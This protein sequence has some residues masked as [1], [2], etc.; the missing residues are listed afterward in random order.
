MMPYTYYPGC[1]L[2]ATGV[3]YDKSMRAVFGKLGLG[4]EE[5]DDWNCCGATSYMSVKETVAFAITARN[6]ALA[7]KN[8]GGD[9]VAPCSACY[10]LL[11]KT[12]KFLGEAPA[13]RADVAEAL[14]EDD[15]ECRLSVPVRHPLEVLMNDVG[16][17][18]LAAA[19]TR[20]I[21]DFRPAC[22]YGCQILRPQRAMDDDPE[23]PMAMEDLFA[24]LGAEPVDYPPRTRCCGG[25][26]M[27]TAEEVAVKLCEELIGWAQ[28]RDANCIVTVCPLCQ[29][30]LDILGR[31]AEL[32]GGG[33]PIP[34]LY[35]TQLL[36]LA[37]GCTRRELGIQHG[38]IPLTVEARPLPVEPAAVGM[39]A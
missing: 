31:R 1:S 35:F 21:A 10:A 3:S 17:E 26:L 24:A 5:L 16:T 29:G 37:L 6:L 13:L 30:N 7:E 20:S 12:R 28:E 38:L 14:A 8:G 9:L 19:Q 32:V 18:R 36:G 33:R 4:L 2:H 34:V 27:A 22:Y 23:V 25:M 15:L 11:N 39:E